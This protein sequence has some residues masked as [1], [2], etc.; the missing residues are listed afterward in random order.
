LGLV[1]LSCGWLSACASVDPSRSR[2]N[3]TTE[4]TRQWPRR[5]GWGGL[6][7]GSPT[8]P[9]FRSRSR[10]TRILF[11]FRACILHPVRCSSSCRRFDAINVAMGNTRPSPY[12]F[13]VDAHAGLEADIIAWDMSM[14]VPDRACGPAAMSIELF[15]RSASVLPR[16]PAVL[17]MD[18]TPD[19]D[20]C[21]DGHLAWIN[22][23]NKAFMGCDKER[24]L[25]NVYREF[26]LHQMPPS[27]LVPGVTCG[28][29]RFARDK[30]FNSTEKDYP[31]PMRWHPG[32]SGHLLL[33]DMLFMHYAEVFL[34]ALGRLEDVAPGVTGAELREKDTDSRTDLETSLGG[35]TS[36]G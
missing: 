30:L 13:C 8:E 24:N 11:F 10:L 31:H 22:R 21:T 34:S 5:V 27:F 32:P 6:R 14:M 9:F 15:I 17:V 4:G 25:M 3:A 33:A 19:Q 23:R 7:L 18:A 26:G 16:H 28:D 1:L 35:L 2:G 36:V 29:E 12:S 20:P